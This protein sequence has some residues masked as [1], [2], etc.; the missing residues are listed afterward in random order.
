MD[1]NQQALNEQ[2][3]EAE[4]QLAIARRRAGLCIH[5][6]RLNAGDDLSPFG[7]SCEDCLRDMLDGNWRNL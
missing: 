1:N 3:A 4:L 7:G 2:L 6:G 5:C